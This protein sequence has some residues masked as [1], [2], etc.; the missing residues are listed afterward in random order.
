MRPVRIFLLLRPASGEWTSTAHRDLDEAIA[1][2]DQFRV[3]S[4]GVGV[5]HVGL[6]LP[7]ARDFD[8]I[9]HNFSDCLLF[10]TSA[11]WALHSIGQFS[12]RIG[13][14]GD[15][16]L[17]MALSGWGYE[18]TEPVAVRTHNIATLA[19][20]AEAA[21]VRHLHELH[22]ELAY[23]VAS[24]GIFDDDS[25]RARDNALEWATRRDLGIARMTFLMA[26][27]DPDDPIDVVK[28]C[29]PWLL[30]A[31]MASINTTVRCA[32]SLRCG[33]VAHVADLLRMTSNTLLKLPNLGK[34]SVRDL[35]Q[36]LWVAVKNGPIACE[37]DRDNGSSFD[38]MPGAQS[39][40]ADTGDAAYGHTQLQIVHQSAQ[41]NCVN[42]F[43][44][45]FAAAMESLSPSQVSVL[46][47]R[48]GL[49]SPALT[50][51][52]L[53]EIMG[54]TRERVR[55]LESKVIRAF[56]SYPVW[57]MEFIPRLAA[58]LG[59]RQDPLPAESLDLF[60]P[61]FAG[62]AAS[63]PELRFIL[64]RV[65]D[66]RFHMFSVSGCEIV[67]EIS[68][69]DWEKAIAHAINI[70]EKCVPERIPKSEVRCRVE[71]LLP[72]QGHELAGDL[73]AIAQQGALFALDVDGVE[74]LVAIGTSGESLVAAVLAASLRPVHYSELP[75]LIQANFGRVIDIRRAHN[76]VNI[77][78]LMYGRGTY[79]TMQ[80]CPLNAEELTLLR[81]AAE[82]LV[83]GGAPERQWTCAEM[84]DLLGGEG[85]NFQ[86][87]VN[88]YLLQIALIGSTVLVDLGRLVWK[89]K[90]ESG[91][92]GATRIDL[93]QAVL[94]IL[95]ANGGPLTRGEIRDRL[96]RDRG[97]SGYFQ[98][99]P[100]GSLIRLDAQ[101]WGLIERDVPLSSEE[102]AQMRQFM[103]NFL[104]HKQSGVHWSEFKTIYA[105]EE[106]LMSNILDTQI[107]QSILA[108]DHRFK[109][110]M[111]G[112][113]YLTAWSGPRRLTQGEAIAEVMRSLGGTGIKVS[114][115][116]SRAS[117]LLG[118][119]VER[120]SVYGAMVSAGAKFDDSVASWFFAEEETS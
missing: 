40:L 50:L 75:K 93:S 62:S 87:R 16:G 65:T 1:L 35:A 79:G 104:F 102:I 9:C 105:L 60:E 17:Y 108:T 26:G 61:W 73:W 44:K 15:I 71:G 100:R 37:D 39:F 115:V 90:D 30:D 5:M 34:K 106:G 96:M 82:T 45:A 12:N 59:E 56:A 48:I 110:S 101:R 57:R 36:S 23:K 64:E 99:N 51:Q 19:S 119:Q 8:N 22:P 95:E 70:M 74:R 76:A 78:G 120:D 49:G 2:W 33:E 86:E 112:Y 92:N 21:W 80:H 88:Q 28:A 43:G 103:A 13:F 91:N 94:S 7:L 98:M 31:R 107:I 25:Y 42:S 77:V 117:A 116:I 20:S 89:A 52:E 66:G 109:T 18:V 29:P 118:R 41:S 97:L 38:K 63:L 67:T 54:V 84:L 47:K 14:V 85:L 83:L 111:S 69:A 11:R 3:Q 68:K 46:Q 81:E 4:G 58:L 32:N 24:A 27:R 10:S 114:E 6:T 72:F 53:G 113:I 55:Q